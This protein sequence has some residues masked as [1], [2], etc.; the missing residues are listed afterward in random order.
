MFSCNADIHSES[1][2]HRRSITLRDAAFLKHVLLL[3]KR[4]L[5][6]KENC[7]FPAAITN[8][9]HMFFW[10]QTLQ[11]KLHQ[12]VSLSLLTQPINLFSVVLPAGQTDGIVSLQRSRPVQKRTYEILFTQAK[13]RI[14]QQGLMTS[15]LQKLLLGCSWSK[16]FPSHCFFQSG[17][18]DRDS[19]ASPALPNPSQ[20][21]LPAECHPPGITSACT[22]RATYTALHHHSSFT[23]RLSHC[24]FF[25]CPPGA[26]TNLPTQASSQ[27][28]LS[29]RQFG[30]PNK[31]T[32]VF[33]L[34]SCCA[35][36]LSFTGSEPYS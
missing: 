9:L 5:E 24:S 15:D 30:L 2:S 28:P 6:E 29:K 10:Q 35:N 19:Q 12:E 23:P 32:P 4:P 18:K 27:G 33:Q 1:P 26:R 21:S 36:T 34:Q 3:F 7:L 11:G 13:G 14:R 25:F 16:T 20:D 22:A 31:L 8:S 17:R